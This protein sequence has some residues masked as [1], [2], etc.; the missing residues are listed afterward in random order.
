MAVVGSFSMAL[1]TVP[2]NSE[3]AVSFLTGVF[4]SAE[5]P[6]CRFLAII[7]LNEQQIE[8]TNLL[9]Y[10]FSPLPWNEATHVAA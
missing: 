2:L 10:L 3:E 7:Y 5:S 6:L 1:N 8:V 4:D 9:I